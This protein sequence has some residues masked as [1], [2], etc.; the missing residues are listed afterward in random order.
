MKKYPAIALIELTNIAAGI[1]TADAMVKT[2]PVSLLK[3]GTVHNGKYLI[4]IS[5]SV[6]SVEEAYKKGL[7]VGEDNVIDKVFLPDIHPQV[8]DAILG[9]RFDISKES[10]GIVETLSVASIII[11][12]DSA[13]K[14]ADINIIEIRLADD[15]GG[16]GFVIYN[17]KIEDV[18]EAVSISKTTLSNQL[19][20]LNITVIPNLHSEMARQLEH[21]TIFSKN[22]LLKIEDGEI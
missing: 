8:Y 11:A 2:A 18:K 7:S 22:K 1:L 3:S 20:S 15:I 16:K 19:E 5:G 10:L 21:T 6:A 12:S 14:S 13:V 17:G 4:L 9:K